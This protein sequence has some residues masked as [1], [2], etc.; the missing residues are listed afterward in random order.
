MADRGPAGQRPLDQRGHD[1]VEAPVSRLGDQGLGAAGD[2]RGVRVPRRAFAGA[3]PLG[4]VGA[5]VDRHGSRSWCGRVLAPRRE[6][7][8][9]MR[10]R[11]ALLAVALSVVVAVPADAGVN[12]LT[13]EWTSNYALTHSTRI[14]R[15]AGSCSA[16]NVFLELATFGPVT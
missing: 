8:Q 16:G 7:G 15:A 6:G 10:R 3:D 5:R 9:V 11:L 13:L 14:E 1:P 12:R 2:R 4:G